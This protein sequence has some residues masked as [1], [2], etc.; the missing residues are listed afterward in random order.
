MKR[1]VGIILLLLSIA[2]IG[3]L[4]LRIWGIEIVSLTA[5]LKSTTT[6]VLLGV[7]IIILIIIYGALLRNDRRGYDRKSGS[8]A[9]PKL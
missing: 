6:L 3:I 8:R 4:V 9:H 1:I 2:L 7:A 5:V